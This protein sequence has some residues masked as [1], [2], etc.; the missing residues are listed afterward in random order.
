[1]RH[2]ADLARTT[3]STIYRQYIQKQSDT[4]WMQDRTSLNALG[5]RWAGTSANQTDWR[6]QASALGALTAAASGDKVT[7]PR[8]WT[9]RSPSA[10]TE[11]SAQ[12]MSARAS[13][14]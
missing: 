6:T 7:N 2:F 1:V 12:S 11:S 5:E 13:G 10:S 3:G 14:M 4:L 9:E 8:T